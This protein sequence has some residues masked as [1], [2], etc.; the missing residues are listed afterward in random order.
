M[1]CHGPIALLSTRPEIVLHN[2]ATD[3]DGP[4]LFPYRGYLVSCYSNR[5]EKAN[6]WMWWG[7]LEKNCEAALREHGVE[8]QT[9]VVPLMEKVVVDREVV[10][11]ENP[12]SAGRLGEAFVEM[13]RKVERGGS[14]LE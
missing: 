7:N 8:V 9:A 4:G 5:E 14:L 12:T 1:I 11:A 2:K 3:P 6:E 13:L 10:S